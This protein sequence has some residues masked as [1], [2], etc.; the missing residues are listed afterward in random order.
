[1]PVRRVRPGVRCF[2]SAHLAHLA[3][4]AY[5][6]SAGKGNAPALDPNAPLTTQSRGF[7][8]VSTLQT[9]KMLQSLAE[10]TSDL[11]GSLEDLSEQSLDEKSLVT[12]HAAHIASTVASLE[13][14]ILA[15]YAEI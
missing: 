2:F 3:Q 12:R 4:V 11:A 5:T 7:R 1:M 6:V 15:M 10:K 8:G 9:V 14:A 13:A